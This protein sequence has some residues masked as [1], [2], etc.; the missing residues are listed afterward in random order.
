MS[1]L[2][3]V[4]LHFAGEFRADVSTVNNDA[5]HYDSANFS[6]DF[7][8]PPNGSWQPAGTGA[9]QLVNCRVT[10]ACYDDGTSAND[11]ATDPVISMKVTEGDGRVSAKLV[12]L[13]PMQQLVSTIYGLQVRI[14]SLD[15]T[16]LLTGE[17]QAAP[18]YDIF[19]TR[20]VGSG[21]GA[22]SAYY[23]SQLRNLQWGD[24]TRSK[25]LQQLKDKSPDNI[26]SMRFMVDGYDLNGPK[27]GYGRIVGTI[28]PGS[29][30]EPMHHIQGRHLSPAAHL[31]PF[32]GNLFGTVVACMDRASRK[33]LVDFGNAIPLRALVPNADPNLQDLVGI[34]SVLP[35]GQL[36]FVDFIQDRFEQKWYENTAGIEALPADRDLS[37]DEISIIDNNPLAV[38]SGTFD[39]IRQ[40][41]RSFSIPAS[42]HPQGIFAR[43]DRLVVRLAPGGHSATT[44]WA[45]KFGKPLVGAVIETAISDTGLQPDP[46]AGGVAQ[47]RQSLSATPSATTDATGRAEISIS[48]D[49]IDPRPYIDGQVYSV[50]LRVRGAAST[51]TD[52]EP[53]CFA[54]VLVYD[55]V[56]YPNRVLWEDHVL[57]VLGQFSNLYP[58]AHGSNPY[59]PF[60]NQPPFHPIVD[61]SDYD[62]VSRFRRHIA[63]AISLPIEHPNHMP[64]TR[65]LSPAKREMLLRFFS[66]LDRGDASRSMPA[67]TAP[68]AAATP[69]PARAGKAAA[70]RGGELGGK[71]AAAA[72]V[73]RTGADRSEPLARLL[74]AKLAKSRG[75]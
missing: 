67:S 55:H 50:E 56:A 7:Q 75:R 15:G 69:A 31:I 40:R 37:D 1:Y 53:R 72:R 64:V 29:G 14:V 23:Q 66:Q 4:R 8:K 16:T 30:S 32:N 51:G 59:E 13:D 54:S 27:R 35:A 12:D 3:R 52:F 73:A 36:Q 42:E 24:I 48:A 25:F 60:A 68:A 57:P 43:F 63:R 46:G 18:F 65:D 61:L 2:D 5:T 39:T 58:R 62:A 41:W 34:A 74:A 71:T 45:T 20:G 70:A 17:F 21:D 22:A 49:H 28:G 11:P 6:E 19:W 26:L 38:V 9:W 33:L 44:A 10:R 47:P